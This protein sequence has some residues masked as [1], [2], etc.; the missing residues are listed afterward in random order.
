MKRWNLYVFTC[1]LSLLCLTVG[2][3]ACD[4]CRL[5]APERI[6]GAV[7]AAPPADMPVSLL[8][9]P[10][11]AGA[12]NAFHDAIW[13]GAETV[14]LSGY[15]LPYTAETREY[16]AEG[17]GYMEPDMFGYNGCFW[18]YTTVDGERILLGA[19]LYY[20]MSPETYAA[21]KEVYRKGV[22]EVTSQVDPA[23]SPVEKPLF[24]H[25]FMAAHYQ[26]DLDFEIYDPVN[27]FARKKG[28][29][30][31]YS[32]AYAAVLKELG[33]EYSYVESDDLN[34]I[35]NLVKVDGLWYH[36]D[37]TWD[38]PI[39]DRLGAAHHARFLMSDTS[40]KI[41]HDND[42]ADDWYYYNGVS[43]QD[44]TYDAYFWRNIWAPFVHADGV[45]YTLSSSGLTS[46]DGV[47]PNLGTVLDR[48]YV[49]C[50]G[51]VYHKGKLYYNTYYNIKSYDLFTQTF[52]TLLTF[53]HTGDSGGQGVLADGDTLH[54]QCYRYRDVTD[55]ET[56]EIIG[57]ERAMAR[58]SIALDPYTESQENGFRYYVS[59]GTVHINQGA[60]PVAVAVAC[61]DSQGRMQDH[62]LLMTSGSYR[63]KQPG[64]VKLIAMANSS[65]LPCGTPVSGTV[66]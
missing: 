1:L 41:N 42:D 57:Q 31:A 59:D 16:L 62:A 52:N 14:D 28:V 5:E 6:D 45:W 46:W 40:S 20:C 7:E 15:G 37:V 38:D 12:R 27:F 58:D 3:S 51:L 35:W 64:R 11:Y 25:D 30:Q 26:Y 39:T 9:A 47:S 50:A 22:T 66:K 48:E 63:L 65:W 24:V 23:W 32:L 33:L 17:T 36:V 54:Y 34:H 4:G 21:A 10:D 44:T 49:S 8:S 56:G 53:S 43:C 60:L 29:C 13:A 19:S 61:Y 2:A 55:P 18:E